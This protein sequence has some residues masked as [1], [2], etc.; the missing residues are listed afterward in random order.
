MRRNGIPECGLGKPHRGG[1]GQGQAVLG[2][3]SE[4]KSNGV[5]LTRLTHSN[6]TLQNFANLTNWVLRT[7]K[8]CK[9]ADLMSLIP[10]PPQLIESI[11]D[12][13]YLNQDPLNCMMLVYTL[14]PLCHSLCAS[15]TKPCYTQP[16]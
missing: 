5:K 9:V 7:A 13:L 2:G 1:T 10:T 6:K 15:H 11:L 8:C 3:Y 14:K 4:G 16:C 12:N